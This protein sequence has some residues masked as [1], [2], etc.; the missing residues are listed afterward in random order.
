MLLHPRFVRPVFFK[1]VTI[2]WSL[3]SLCRMGPTSALRLL[4]LGILLAYGAGVA[5]AQE[6]ETADTGKVLVIPLKNQ[7]D[8]T[9]LFFLRRGFQAARRDSD[10]RAIVIDM[11]TPGGELRTTEEIIS[12]MRSFADENIPIYSFVNP[13]AQSAGA[14]ICLASDKIFM[15]PGSRIGSA[16]PIL[17]DPSGG[18][19]DLPESVRE[20]ILS[21]TRALVRGVARENGYLP[22]LAT[23]MVDD[24]VEVTVGDRVVCREGELLNLTADE[25]VEIIPPMTTPLLA[26]AIVDDVDG[27]LVYEHLDGLERVDIAPVGAEALARWLTMLSP[28]LMSIAFL[29]IYM[30]MK[31]PGLGIPGLIGVVCIALFLFGHYIAGLAG[32]EDVFLVVLGIILIAVEVFVLPGVGLCGFLGLAALLGG[33]ILA[34]IPMM[35]S[36]PELPGVSVEPV[37][38]EWFLKQ[39]ML[40]MVSTFAIAGGGLYILARTLPKTGFY[41]KLVLS[42][43]E[44]VEE[45]YVGVNIE[46]N[47]KL[48]G[49]RGVAVTPLRLSGIVKIGADRID[50]VSGGD[51]I[52]AGETVV[53]TE[54]DGPRVVVEAA[55]P[56]PETDGDKGTS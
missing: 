36:V 23:A 49:Q 16:A 21:D 30:E 56:D 54:I 7:I 47:R 20:K 2:V 17:I 1:S 18:I 51:Y 6:S 27:L 45:G 13:R 28:F 34:M 52:D 55:G 24:S 14:I 15:A 39:A 4:I 40:K 46:E 11:D 29:C 48:V 37:N 5:G 8:K 32:S 31:T 44:T 25:A 38:V 3:P 53:V 26:T 43:S 42:S 19:V 9:E 35:P 12:W 33:V 41:S 10:V 50:V 22:E